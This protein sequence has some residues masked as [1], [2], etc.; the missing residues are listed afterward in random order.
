MEKTKKVLNIILLTLRK[1]GLYFMTISILVG[2][3]ATIIESGKYIYS[4]FFVYTFIASLLFAIESYIFK[5]KAIKYILQILIHYILSS[6][7]FVL[8]LV[9][10]SGMAGENG[11]SAF[12]LFIV[13]TVGYAI[14]M[15]IYTIFRNILNKNNKEEKQEYHNQFIKDNN[16]VKK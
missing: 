4:N 16:E 5:I 8:V 1:T 13:Y 9:V 11:K 10:F 3:I 15:T 7:T 12:L 2:I 6:S 14:V